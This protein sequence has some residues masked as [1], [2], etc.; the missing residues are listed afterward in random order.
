[1]NLSKALFGSVLNG[2]FVSQSGSRTRI[3]EELDIGVQ[4]SGNI[5]GMG[6]VEVKIE[7]FLDPTVKCLNNWVICGSS[8]SRHRAKYVIIMVGLAKS[9]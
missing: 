3:I 9:P 5:T 4:E 6:Q 8:P 7:L 2:A 1:M